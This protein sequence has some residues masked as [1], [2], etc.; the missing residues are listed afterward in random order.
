MTY[1]NCNINTNKRDKSYQFC[2]TAILFVK[3]K[4]LFN[5]QLNL[6]FIVLHIHI[7]TNSD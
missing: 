1:I 2:L 6:L 5:F 7:E 3:L 4:H